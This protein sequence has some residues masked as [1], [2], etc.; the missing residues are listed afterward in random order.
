MAKGEEG[1]GQNMLD[2]TL[3]GGARLCFFLYWEEFLPARD[4]LLAILRGES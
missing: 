3:R 2:V 1:A 4:K